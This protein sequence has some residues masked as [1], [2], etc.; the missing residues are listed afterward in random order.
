V[1]SA[2]VGCAVLRRACDSN[3]P[4]TLAGAIATDATPPSTVEGVRMR[5][6]KATDPAARCRGSV[7]SAQPEGGNQ[8]VQGWFIR[9]VGPGVSLGRVA[10]TKAVRNRFSIRACAP[11]STPVHKWTGPPIRNWTP[12]PRPEILPPT[13][14]KAQRRGDRRE[15]TG[16]DFL[17]VPPRQ[18]S[19]GSRQR[20]RTQHRAGGARPIK[21][22]R[23]VESAPG[24]GR[25]FTF[26]VPAEKASALSTAG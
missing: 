25:T 20:P 8:L 22:G 19:A 12:V 6:P 15:R 21:G 17:L 2:V 26:V 14:A 13:A 24:E 5:A 23:Q 11:L 9:R 3:I 4:R 10:P 7:E 16:T 18:G 1:D